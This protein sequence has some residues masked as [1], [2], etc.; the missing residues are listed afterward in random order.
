MAGVEW[1]ALD[2]DEDC[3]VDVRARKRIQNAVT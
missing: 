2:V 3:R 1:A